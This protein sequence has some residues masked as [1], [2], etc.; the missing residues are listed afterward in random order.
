MEID[1]LACGEGLQHG[2]RIVADANDLE[3]CSAELFAV[4]LQLNQLLLA[5]RSPV[6][7]AIKHQGDVLRIV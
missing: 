2:Y 5:E 6:S 7:G 4:C 3:V 1:V